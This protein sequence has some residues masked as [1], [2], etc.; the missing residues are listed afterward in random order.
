MFGP[1]GTGKSSLLQALFSEKDTLY[2]DLLDNQLM[3]EQARV[4][5]N[6]SNKA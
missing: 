4:A 6:L 2:L 5:E 3:D 1:R